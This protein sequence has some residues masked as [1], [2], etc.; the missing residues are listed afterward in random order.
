MI[1]A[2][3]ILPIFYFDD[4]VGYSFDHSGQ[5]GISSTVTSPS[6][7]PIHTVGASLL[8]LTVVPFWMYSPVMALMTG[9]LGGDE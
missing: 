6:S 7:V 1:C 4:F 3:C 2:L 8:C 5:P 9:G